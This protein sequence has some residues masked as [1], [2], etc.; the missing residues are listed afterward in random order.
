MTSDH[1]PDE[2]TRAARFRVRGASVRR[3]E[4]AWLRSFLVL[5]V[6]LVVITIVRAAALSLAPGLGTPR[7]DTLTSALAALSWAL[8]F[9]PL[10][11]AGVLTI[12]DDGVHLRWRG[13][14]R[15]VPG[16]AIKDA[17]VID[18]EVAMG[19]RATVLRL[20]LRDGTTF[21]AIFA[22][23]PRGVVASGARARALEAHRCAQA[24]IEEAVPVEPSELAP[25]LRRGGEDAAAWVASLRGRFGKVASFRDDADG[26][27]GALWQL[28]ADAQRAPETRA[29]AAVAVWPTADEGGR[30]RL[31][32]IAE[33][34]AVPALRAA[35]EATMRGDEAALGEALERLDEAAAAAR[36][37]LDEL[38]EASPARTPRRGG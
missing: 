6:A 18:E 8:A 16:P 24:L 3:W 7:L 1:R 37:E 38:D 26:R 23:R 36:G 28:V 2:R 17:L 13:R 11:R 35:F 33:G 32:A 22:V 12:G 29:A 20:Y 4:L 31:A 10:F 19:L 25:Q 21:D 27:T 15:F 34:T 9:A 30:T 5:F 14:A